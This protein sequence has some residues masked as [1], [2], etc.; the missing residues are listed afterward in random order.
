MYPRARTPIGSADFPIEFEIWGTNIPPKEPSLIGDGSLLA[1]LQYWT[2]WSIVSGGSE[3]PDLI[4]NGQD[5][6][7]TDPDAGWTRL[8]SC[9]YRLP[10]GIRKG[11]G[12]PNPELSAEDQEYF[13]AGLVYEFPVEMARITARYL[14]FVI[15]E[16]SKDDKRMSILEQ[17]FR[18]SY[19]N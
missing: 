19:A 8:D 1:N 10:S 17:E 5:T 9:S 4:V 13:N 16:T 2:S 18:G 14:R 6:W 12:W 3:V 15:Y 7:K 11:M